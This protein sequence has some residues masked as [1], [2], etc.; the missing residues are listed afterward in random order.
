MKNTK[1]AQCH[2]LV[3]IG[4]K[5]DMEKLIEKGEVYMNTTR[6]FKEH[7]NSEIGDTFEGALHIKDG[8]VYEYRENID[9][10]KLFCIWHINDREPIN[11]E[12]IYKVYYN[13]EPYKTK[14]ALD[15]R[16]LSG[17][18]D[19]EEAYMVVINNV[20]EFNV[21]F[22]KACKELNL[23]FIDNRIVSYYDELSKKSNEIITPFMKRNKYKKQQE[24]RYLVHKSDCNPIKIY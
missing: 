4:R 14:I 24:V 9:N 10:E 7:K 2:L 17:L 13:D 20:K 11:E 3:K 1:T 22:K 15:L 12:L 19:D 16:K 6:Y 8:K 21:R 5:E 18:T 23:E